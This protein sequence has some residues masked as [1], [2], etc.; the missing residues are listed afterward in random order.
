MTTLE[1]WQ[2][3]A[4]GLTPRNR[5]LIDGEWTDAVDG[6]TFTTVNPATGEAIVE[7]ASGDATDIDRA[8]TSA[9]TAFED[10][11]WSRLSPRD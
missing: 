7:V 2:D 5:A 10:G 3:A 6:A 4:A 8:V 11:R 9:R 1:Y